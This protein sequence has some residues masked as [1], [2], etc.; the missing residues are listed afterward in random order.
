MRIGGAYPFGQAAV[1]IPLKSGQQFY[2]PPGNFF[3][4]MGQASELQYFDPNNLCWRGIV[5]PDNCYT[6]YNTDGFNYRIAN[7]SGVVNGCKITNAGSGAVNG[8]G[9]AATGVTVSFGAAPSNGQAATAYPIVGGQIPTT[10]TITQAGS[11]FTVPPLI[12]IDPP[13]PGGI[14][15]TAVCTISA[16]AINAVTVTNQGAGYT[17]VPNVWVIPQYA[18]YQGFGVPV[19]ATPPVNTIPPGIVAPVQG[20]NSYPPFLPFFDYAAVSGTTGALLTA[21]ALTGSGTLTGIVMQSYGGGYAGTTIPTITIT[22]AGAA[23]ATPLM[24]MSLQSITITAGGAAYAGTQVLL[25]SFGLIQATDGCNGIFQPRS[26][27]GTATQSGGVINAT[28]IED[29]G[30]GFQTVPVIGVIQTNTTPATTI[31]TLTAV[32]GGINDVILV[33]PA[34]Q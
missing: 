3:I 27:R 28:V 1:P 23:A 26:A 18:T 20:I 13:P 24:S 7:Q 31:A 10:I 25:S 19:N 33:Q 4:S 16:G 32:V 9:A 17:S 11:G 5:T 2:L 22:G 12:L 8:I 15:A 30:F 6:L 34:A 29:P 14:Q 21:G